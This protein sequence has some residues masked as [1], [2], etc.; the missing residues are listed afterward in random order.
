MYEV[1]NV[2]NCLISSGMLPKSFTWIEISILHQI[3]VLEFQLLSYRTSDTRK[4]KWQCSQNIDLNPTC[5]SA[6]RCLPIR[7]GLETTE[8]APSTYF[9]GLISSPQLSE[10][11]QEIM[12]FAVLKNDYCVIIRLFT[13][14]IVLC[15]GM[16]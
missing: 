2:F 1:Q 13:N 5:E 9:A 14:H 8:E 11:R 10:T 16:G 7:A 15:N 3:Y 4:T 12:L 6:H